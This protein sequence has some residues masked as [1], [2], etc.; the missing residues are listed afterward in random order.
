MKSNVRRN[1]E[2]DGNYA[3]YCMRCPRLVRMEKTA[4]FFWGCAQ[5]G[6]Q[7]DEREPYMI[8]FSWLSPRKDGSAPVKV[9]PHLVRGNAAAIYLVFSYLGMNPDCHATIHHA[10][11]TPANLGEIH[12]DVVRDL[13][14][15]MPLPYDDFLA[16]ANRMAGK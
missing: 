1:A 2:L 16:F 10:D 11:D 13:T 8:R 3:P 7:C 14:S 12:A 4:P 5:C 15:K 9:G 6:A